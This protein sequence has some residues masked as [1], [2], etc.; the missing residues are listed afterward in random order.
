MKTTFYAF[1]FITLACLSACSK[2]KDKDKSSA[3]DILSFTVDSK[4]WQISGT[5][6]TGMY[7]KGTAQGNLAPS[8]TVSDKATVNPPSGEPQNFFAAEGVRYTVTAQD[9]KTKKTYT[10]KAEL[11]LP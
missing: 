11:M 3:C 10:A 2:N 9:G 5:A 8:I 4:N 7:P 6:I 1:L